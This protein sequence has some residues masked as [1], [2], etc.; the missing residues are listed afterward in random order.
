MQDSNEQ[1]KKIAVATTK[2]R[3]FFIGNWKCPHKKHWLDQS[4]PSNMMGPMENK[5]TRL[6][7]PMENKEQGRWVPWLILLQSIW[8]QG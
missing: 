3:S 4:A 7:G 2:I 5:G 8:E 1:F 6:M